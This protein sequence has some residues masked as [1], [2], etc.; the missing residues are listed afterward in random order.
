MEVLT[1][2]SRT[3]SGSRR[4]ITKRKKNPNWRI[5]KWRLTFP[6]PIVVADD[7]D[8]DH[9]NLEPVSTENII[10]GG[11]RTRGKNIDFAEAA[12]K[13]K[14]AGDEMEDDDEDEDFA[15]P[16]EDENKRE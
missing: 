5:S 11:R 15:A 6:F 1:I 8:E 2:L 7:D 3:R 16:E 10:S 9:D 12:E 4:W 14:D 13:S